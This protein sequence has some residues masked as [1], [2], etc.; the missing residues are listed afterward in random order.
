MIPS[1]RL[2][3]ALAMTAAPQFLEFSTPCQNVAESL[4][5]Y[6]QLGFTE[7][8]TGD[9][10][11]QQYA[12]ITDGEFCMGLYSNDYPSPG[13][14]FVQQNLATRV[15]RELLADIPFEFACL[16][17][18][19]FHEAALTDPDGT[20]AV[21]LEAR[22]FSGALD[23]IDTPMIGRLSHIALP[24][25]RIQDTVAFWQNYGF[26]AVTAEVNGEEQAELHTPGLLVE[27][28]PG[29]RKITLQFKADNI[30]DSILSIKHEHSVRKIHSGY[31]LIA[32]E[33]TR[34]IIS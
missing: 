8:F 30:E 26:I 9:M 28:V 21:L 25:M 22:T 10:R 32:P 17:E 31:E 18:D 13:L 3:M 15:R 33:G 14:S 24:C 6:R 12:V 20:L 11:S 16:G 7:L 2:P 1:Y 5:W 29:S 23:S 27:L 34:L 4:T 19:E